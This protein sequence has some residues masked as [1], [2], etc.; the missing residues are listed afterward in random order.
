MQKRGS[1]KTV[2]LF[3]PAGLRQSVV[4]HGAATGTVTP[5]APQ[6]ATKSVELVA[7]GLV[8]VVSK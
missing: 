7:G 4:I 3:A 5:G 1:A 8:Q 6:D 2:A